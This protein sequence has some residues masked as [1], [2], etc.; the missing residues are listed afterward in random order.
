[1]RSTSL[2]ARSQ[3]DPEIER[4]RPPE[5]REVQSESSH[6][7]DSQAPNEVGMLGSVTN[8]S[9]WFG[10]FVLLEELGRGLP[11]RRPGPAAR[12]RDQGASSQAPGDLA[13]PGDP[14]DTPMTALAHDVH[15][16]RDG[17]GAH[18]DGAQFGDAP[19]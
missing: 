9:G 12:R 1:M 15:R 17:S 11:R 14:P 10:R 4:I 8:S 5:A 7:D 13:T 18:R 6:P 3:L 16:A 19:T 2:R